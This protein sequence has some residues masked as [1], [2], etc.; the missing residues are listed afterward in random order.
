MSTDDPLG[1]AQL[2]KHLRVAVSLP[3]TY[4]LDGD[5]VPQDGRAVDI[6]GGGMRF[7]SPTRVQPQRLLTITLD[8]HPGLSLQLRGRSL[9]IT[10]NPANDV[11]HHRSFSRTSRITL[12]TPSLCTLVLLGKL[13]S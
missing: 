11:H 2:R 12:D 13:R 8:L 3:L 4:I 9:A 7:E 5:R 10:S 6:G 1:R